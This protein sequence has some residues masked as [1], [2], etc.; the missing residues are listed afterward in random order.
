MALTSVAKIVAV[1]VA[2][3]V[4]LVAVV[5]LAQRRLVYQPDTSSPPPVSEVVPNAQDVTLTTSDDVDLGAWY[6]RASNPGRDFAVLVANGNGGNRSTRISLALALRERGF[7]VLLFDYRGYGGNEGSPT[8]RG[9]A[10]DVRAARRFLITQAGIPQE[11]LIYF[12]ESLGCA[13]V[14]ELATEFP[15]AGLLLRSPFTDL[16]AAAR[17]QVPL[18][19]ADMLLWDEFEVASVVGRLNVPTT[20]V[21]GTADTVVPPEQSRSVAEAVGGDVVV[22]E[23]DGAD[24]NDDVLFDG[25]RL[26]DA[27]ADLAARI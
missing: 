26:L 13:V 5:W 7:D 17:A 18:V 2:I 10:L 1:V 23:V 25:D 21:Y 22:V 4:L 11:R 15:P 27:V 19:P 6:V 3:F 8:E 9:L 12:G 16:A 20:I 24:H 14:A